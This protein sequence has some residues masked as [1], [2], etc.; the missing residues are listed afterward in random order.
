MAEHILEIKKSTWNSPY[1]TCP[2]CFKV[3]NLEFNPNSEREHQR[4]AD[5]AILKRDYISKQGA[6]DALD[7]AREAICDAVCC[8]DGLDG[9]VGQVVIKWLTDILGDEDEFVKN[10]SGIKDKNE[11]Y[12]NQAFQRCISKEEHKKVVG[13]IYEEIICPMCYRLNPQHATMDN[14]QGCKTCGEKQKYLGGE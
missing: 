4:N 6:V 2:D 9:G 3:L 11:E 14:G 5:E 1:D 10:H 7:A 12:I 13:E 8:E